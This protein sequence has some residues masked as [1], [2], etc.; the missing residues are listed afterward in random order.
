M[1]GDLL[2][3]KKWLKK[4]LDEKFEEAYPGVMELLET[5]LDEIIFDINLWLGLA[6]IA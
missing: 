3:P 4:W 2:I 5:K 6:T 1:V